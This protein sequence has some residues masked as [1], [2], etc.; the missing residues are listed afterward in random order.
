MGSLED[1]EQWELYRPELSLAIWKLM[2]AF[3]WRFLPFPGNL[4]EQP[5]WLIHDIS[6]LSWLNRMIRRDLNLDGGG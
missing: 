1:D 4:L 5:D 6:T 3:N 2:E